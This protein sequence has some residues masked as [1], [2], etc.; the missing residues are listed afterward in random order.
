MTDF[1]N[2][3]KKNKKKQ[4]NSFYFYTN[5]SQNQEIIILKR[6]QNYYKTI[7]QI[8]KTLI[9]VTTIFKQNN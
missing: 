1:Q 2:E 9:F 4:F 7:K 5:Q 3:K 6:L 8:G